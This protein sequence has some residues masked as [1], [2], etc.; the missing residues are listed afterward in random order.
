MKKKKIIIIVV[1]LVVVVAA[2]F[3]F[4]KSSGTVAVPA[5]V[6]QFIPSTQNPSL[7]VTQI[8]PSLNSTD[9]ATLSGMITTIQSG[10]TWTADQSNLLK[11]LEA[12]YG[13]LFSTY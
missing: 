9:M 3:L 1:V 12:K 11:T 7:W 6:Q 5:N 2:Y 8:L 13:Q 10:G 4:F